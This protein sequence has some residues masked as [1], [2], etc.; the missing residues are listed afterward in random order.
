MAEDALAVGVVVLSHYED[1]FAAP[2]PLPKMDLV[3]VPD[4]AAGAMENWGLVT[5][6]Y[7]L[8]LF[9]LTATCLL[10]N[11]QLLDSRGPKLHSVRLYINVTAFE[12][13]YQNNK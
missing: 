2:Y 11:R 12:R 6:R 10:L 9:K 13:H 8:S 5:F 1:F 7:G 4:F 3:A